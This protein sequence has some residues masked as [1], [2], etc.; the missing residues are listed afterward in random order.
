MS[1]LDKAYCREADISGSNFN[2][3]SDSLVEINWW[4]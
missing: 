4:T 2:E 3:F 1:L